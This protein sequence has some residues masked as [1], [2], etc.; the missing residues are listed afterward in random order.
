MFGNT[1]KT[2]S[3]M[4]TTTNKSAINTLVNGTKI[5]GTITAQNDIRI[6][7]TVDGTLNCSGKLIIGAE[8]HV[9]GQ[10][11]CQNA[12]IEGHFQ[13]TLIVNDVLDVRENANVVGEIKTGKLNIQNGA[14]FNGNCDMGNKIKSIPQSPQNHTQE[15]ASAS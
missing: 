2:G 12:V 6:D 4:A 3:E 15:E 9:E 5:E 10:A 13:G 11:S 7:G 8:G 14:T 1:K